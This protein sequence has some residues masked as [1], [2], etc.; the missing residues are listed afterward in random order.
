MSK[1]GYDAIVVGGGPAGSVAALVLAKAG[2]RVALVDKANVGRDKA[3]GDLVG[4]R[5]VRLLDDLGLSLPNSPTAGD[6]IVAGPTGRRVLLPARAGRTYAGHAVIVPRATF[7]AHLRGAALEAGAIDVSMRVASVE[8]GRVGFDGGVVATAD[9]V[10]GAD[11]ATSTTAHAAGLV[12]SSKVLWGFAIRGYVPSDIPIPV[13]ALWNDRPRRG[14]PG[15]GWLFPG[16][17]GANLGL[18]I[19]L[20]H[21]RRDAQRAQQ[22]LDAFRL[23][24]VRI[25]LLGAANELPIRLLGGWLKMGIVGTR[26]AEGKVLL[27]GDAAGLVNPLQGE[28]IAQA[29]ASGQAAADAVVARPGDAAAAYR[30]WV[31]ATYGEWTSVTTPIHAGLVGHPRVIAGVAMAL[32]APVLGSL[33][34]PTWAI[35]WNNLIDGAASTRTVTAA[36]AVHRVGRIV[37][38]PSRRRRNEVEGVERFLADGR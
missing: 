14:F 17:D 30:Q 15:Y 27:V 34:A 4:P 35:Y 24:L 5:G 7:D 9:F 32:T 22:Q 2:A 13:I 33:I 8:G 25:G 10:I 20:G 3:C 31:E 37:T 18:G 1:A 29:L 11:G 6:M 38:S 16:P 12:D 21:S 26:A 19:G 36:R 23:H 28:G